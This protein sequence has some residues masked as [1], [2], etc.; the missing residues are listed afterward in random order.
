MYK[1]LLTPFDDTTSFL[2]LERPESIADKLFQIGFDFIPQNAF[3]QSF[4]D[5][6]DRLQGVFEKMFYDHPADASFDTALQAITQEFFKPAEIASGN[7]AS[8]QYISGADTPEGYNIEVLFE[9]NWSDAQIA[10]VQNVVE[11]ISETIVSDLPDVNG[12]DDLQITASLSINDGYG[13]I[14][15][16]GGIDA[17]RGLNALPYKGYIQLDVDDANFLI[18]NGTWEDLLYHEILH[19]MGFGLTWEIHDLVQSVD[20]VLRFTGRAAT[21]IYNQEFASIAAHDNGSSQGI[22]LETS[23]G[24]GTAESHWDEDIFG[25]EI[26]TGTLNSTNVI[27]NLTV[28]S[29]QD[30]GYETILAD[31]FL[32]S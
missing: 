16:H 21:Q 4:I 18:N 8:L 20:G 13:G 30:I 17:V 1:K 7:Q 10:G 28:A 6:L 14:I 24:P 29:L 11:R 5:I 27:S 15:G 12:I 2:D 22:P 26:M 9:G 31:E 32:F 19:A 3:G 23:G 25:N